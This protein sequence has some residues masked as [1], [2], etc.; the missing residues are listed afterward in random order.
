MA[1]GLTQGTHVSLHFEIFCLREYNYMVYLCHLTEYISRNLHL[2]PLAEKQ[3]HLFSRFCWPTK[4]KIYLHSR[5]LVPGKTLS[6]F[7]KIKPS[8]LSRPALWDNYPWML[9]L[10]NSN[11]LSSSATLCKTL[12]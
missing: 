3:K 4:K 1:F 5:N 6:C 2:F 11:I 10:C 8:F 7:G 9:H 12:S